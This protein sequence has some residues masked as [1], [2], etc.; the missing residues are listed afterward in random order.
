MIESQVT[1][2]L[3]GPN[4][5]KREELLA[6]TDK[7]MSKPEVRALH[8]VIKELKDQVSKYDEDKDAV[9]KRIEFILYLFC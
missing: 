5:T 8:D 7:L 6:T 3:N 4:G 2:V 9:S 1:Q